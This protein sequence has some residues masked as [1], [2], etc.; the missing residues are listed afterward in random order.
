MGYISTVAPSLAWARVSG[1]R[2]RHEDG[3]RQHGRAQLGGCAE[4]EDVARARA[5]RLAR[6]CSARRL[7]SAQH[8]SPALILAPQPAICADKK[9]PLRR[10]TLRCCSITQPTRANISMCI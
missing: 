5:A 8:M 1:F 2:A 9:V 6:G 7:W 3:V 10:D 4:E